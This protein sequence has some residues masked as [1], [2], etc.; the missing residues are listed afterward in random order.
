MPAFSGGTLSE[1]DAIAHCRV[2][3]ANLVQMFCLVLPVP[4]TVRTPDHTE[5]Q[6]EA[7]R[8]RD[9][10]ARRLVEQLDPQLHGVDDAAGFDNDGPIL[11]CGYTLPIFVSQL[12]EII[13]NGRFWVQRARQNETDGLRMAYMLP[14]AWASEAGHWCA[15]LLLCQGG[16]ARALARYV[17]KAGVETRVLI[18]PS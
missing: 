14:E 4:S 7:S 3:L 9:D 12:K 2:L 11:F 5:G 6:D 1:I 8:E 17:A 10:C 16:A 13:G 18:F 15:P